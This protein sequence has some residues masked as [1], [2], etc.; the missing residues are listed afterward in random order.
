MKLL[1]LFGF[2]GA[3]FASSVWAGPAEIQKS[4]EESFNLKIESVEKTAYGDLYEVVTEDTII[5]TDEKASFVIAGSLI[6]AK[7]REDITEKSLKKLA[8]ADFKKLPLDKAVKTVY[9]KGERQIITFEDPNCGYCKRLYQELSTLDNV[10]VYTFLIPIL[11]KDSVQKVSHIWC[12]KDRAETWK[13]WMKDGV[14]PAAASCDDEPTDEVMAYA[15]KLQVRGT[16]M[17]LMANGER[18]NGYAQASVI[19]EALSR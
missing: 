14:K 12:S 8:A 5:Y 7:T 18:M 13:A 15:R 4:L 10:T 16:P 17:V 6:D 9:G 2:A 11:G 19:E 1:S 3:M